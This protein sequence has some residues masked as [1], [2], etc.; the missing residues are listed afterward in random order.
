MRDVC[1]SHCF[2]VISFSSGRSTALK[3]G[4]A[5]EIIDQV[6]HADLDGGAGDTDGAHDQPHAMLLASINML[7]VGA[8]FGL[9]GVRLSWRNFPSI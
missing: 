7:D 2:G 4:E 5:L 3:P 6:G 1:S 9:P 8:N